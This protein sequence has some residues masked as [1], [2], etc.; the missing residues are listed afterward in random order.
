MCAASFRGPR[1]RLRRLRQVAITVAVALMHMLTTVMTA[2]GWF[3]WSSNEPP[4]ST[5]ASAVDTATGPCDLYRLEPGFDYIGGDIGFTAVAVDNQWE[6]CAACERALRCNAFTFVGEARQCWLKAGRRRAREASQQSSLVSGHRGRLKAGSV[7]QPHGAFGSDRSRTAAAR[8]HTIRTRPFGFATGRLR[9]D[10]VRQ[11]QDRIAS[12]LIGRAEHSWKGA[13]RGLASI[14][15][16]RFSISPLQILNSSRPLTLTS[17]VW[18]HWWVGARSAA[19]ALTIETVGKNTT[20]PTWR[21][22]VADYSRADSVIGE[23]GADRDADDRATDGAVG[24]EVAAQLPDLAAQLPLKSLSS[25][26]RAATSPLLARLSARGDDGNWVR[27]RAT[28]VSALAALTTD[29]SRPTRILIA[30]SLPGSSLLQHALIGEAVGFGHA[31]LLTTHVPCPDAGPGGRVIDAGTAAGVPTAQSVLT[32]LAQCQHELSRLTANTALMPAM[33]GLDDPRPANDGCRHQARPWWPGNGTVATESADCQSDGDAGKPFKSSLA[34]T[35]SWR[36]M[37]FLALD[38][39]NPVTV[40]THQHAEARRIARAV[41]ASGAAWIVA[42]GEAGTTASAIAQSRAALAGVA[43]LIVTSRY[44][45]IDGYHHRAAERGAA[46]LVA[47]GG[48]G[49]GA[50]GEGYARLRPLNRTS[51]LFERVR[52]VDGAV[53]GSFAVGCRQLP[54]HRT[55]LNRGRHEASRDPFSRDRS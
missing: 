13:P 41:R 38:A 34:Y 8:P 14:P 44:P 46:A 45:G 27:Y 2:S 24:G 53:I 39:A 25:L 6:C 9:E 28:A 5:V 23:G 29:D 51:L 32:P 22:R 33:S 49:A 36:R 47:L 19:S 52:V 17:S 50:H 42:Y 30:D 16:L 20:P 7:G 43:D 3:G 26:A 11:A 48:I 31:L 12:Q 18:A 40:G 15:L 10:G 55:M 37:V 54:R 21:V 4:A 1:G 35:F